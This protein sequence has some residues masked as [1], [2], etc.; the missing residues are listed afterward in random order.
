MLLDDLV[1]LTERHRLACPFYRDYTDSMFADATMAT[2]LGDLPYIPVRAFKQFDLKSVP[3]DHVY[4]VM[5]SSGTSGSHSRIFLD[6]DTAKNQTISL[7][8]VF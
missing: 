8:I 4:K 1:K 3:D 2:S 5:R 6:R 7:S